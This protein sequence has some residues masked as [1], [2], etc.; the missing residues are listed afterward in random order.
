MSTLF[1]VQLYFSVFTVL[2]H[3]QVGFLPAKMI[4]ATLGL[5]YAH[6]TFMNR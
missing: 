1:R 5:M 2:N 6:R 4:A 3:S